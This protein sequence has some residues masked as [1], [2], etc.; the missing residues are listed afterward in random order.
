MKHFALSRAIALA[1]LTATLPQCAPAQPT[2]MPA[3]QVSVTT[4]N[5]TSN[6]LVVDAATD[7]TTE[8]PVNTLQ[9]LIDNLDLTT[10][11][12]TLANLHSYMTSG[13]YTNDSPSSDAPTGTGFYYLDVDN[14]DDVTTNSF[15]TASTNATTGWPDLDTD[16]TDD[17]TNIIVNADGDLAPITDGTAD[18]SDYVL[19]GT[20]I[21]NATYDSETKTWTLPEGAGKYS[22]EAWKQ[23][24]K[25]TG[26]GDT[27]LRIDGYAGSIQNGSLTNFSE[28]SGL[29]YPPVAGFYQFNAIVTAK[30]TSDTYGASTSI[31]KDQHAYDPDNIS[32]NGVNVTIVPYADALGWNRVTLAWYTYV[33]QGDPVGV[34]AWNAASWATAGFQ[35][36]HVSFGGFLVKEVT[37]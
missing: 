21:A 3:K 22:F 30:N 2:K 20:N 33:D 17:V 37:E 25:T 19:Q 14:R 8:A 24:D 26:D 23:S 29:Y 10:N 36:N 35:I 4:S 12:V 15:K 18:I 31:Y 7:P 13:V 11:A 6:L 27:G 5:N 32:T 9:L 16:H 1:L 28:S 34:Y